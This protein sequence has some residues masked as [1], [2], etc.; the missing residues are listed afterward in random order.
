MD[1][2]YREAVAPEDAV[3]GVRSITSSSRAGG[4]S[5][6]ALARPVCF[7]TRVETRRLVPGASDDAVSPFEDI[8]EYCRKK[9]N[10]LPV[11]AST[12]N[13]F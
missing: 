8:R 13:R 7:L 9:D 3:S 6:V 4:G 11:S 5:L 10:H 1:V 2:A 12:F